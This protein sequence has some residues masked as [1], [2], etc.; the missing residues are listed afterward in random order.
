[1]TEDNVTKRNMT[2]FSK[3]NELR[4]LCS[5]HPHATSW[6]EGYK[7][8]TLDWSGLG[9]NIAQNWC[10]LSV[11]MGCVRC[12]ACAR[13]DCCD[14]LCLQGCVACAAVIGCVCAVCDELLVSCVSTVC[15]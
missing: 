11:C 9:Y 13:T 14:R 8:W 2:V 4:L 6:V 10:L 5:N 3:G 12:V 15:F 7:T 1:M